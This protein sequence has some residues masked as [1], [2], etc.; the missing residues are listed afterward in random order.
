KK[1]S[2]FNYKLIKKIVQ[3]KNVDEE[4]INYAQK[5]G[6]DL[7]IISLSSKKHAID[8]IMGHVTLRVV[9][10]ARIPVLVIPVIVP[11]VPDWNE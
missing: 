11:S 10:F 6:V 1:E 2:D 3:G 4:I 9:E 8:I 5:N 7:I